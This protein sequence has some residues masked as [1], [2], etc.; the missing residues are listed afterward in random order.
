MAPR[1]VRLTHGPLK[2]GQRSTIVAG[3][4]L[5]GSGTGAAAGTYGDDSHVAQLVVDA[6]GNITAIS[7]VAIAG[8][9][10]GAPAAHH[11]THENGGS[12]EVSLDAS[13]I[14]TGALAYARLPVGTTASTV[15]AGDDSRMTNAR[16]PTAHH[17]T[18]E[19]G[20]ADELALD[21]AQ[22]TSGTIDDARIPSGIARDSEVTTAVSA[23]ATARDAAI[24]LAVANLINSS[25]GALDTLKELADALGDDASFAATMTTALGGKQP[26][27]GALT[28]IV[29]LTP[30]NDDIIQRKSGTWIN[31]TMP[32]LKTDLVLVKGDIGLGNVDNVADASKPVSTAQAA[33]DALRILDPS[34]ANDDFLQRKAGAWANRTVAQVKTDLGLVYSYLFGD[35]SDG[36]VNF[37][38]TTTLLGLVPSSNVY[39]L[40]RDLYLAGGSQLSASAVISTAGFRIFCLGGAL[41]IG[42]SATV[43]HTANPASTSTGGAAGPSTVNGGLCGTK[44]G[45]G[46]AG[47]AGATGNA[48]STS[49][50]AAGGAGGIATGGGMGGGTA[51]GLST[52]AV[53]S[54]GGDPRNVWQAQALATANLTPYTGGAGGAGGTAAAGTGLGGGGGA[55]GGIVM[56]YAQQLINSGT[57]SAIGGVGGQGTAGTSTNVGGGGGGGGGAI[58]LVVG[59]GSSTGTLSVA[60]GA[61]G[62]PRGTGATG[63]TGSTGNTYVLNA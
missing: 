25:P 29:A 5:G 39:T 54:A 55:G 37:D 34:G 21:S 15:A 60:G 2:V 3:I 53:A 31:R 35:G 26:L 43:R 46:A 52:K 18:H 49:V 36:I 14:V 50:G 16:T 11:A 19:H 17:T 28:A 45:N 40:T 61:G 47:A 56:I 59:A 57:I 23:E 42:A 6:D 7:E 12:D 38:G 27:A 48:T 32:Q 4:P 63:A 44:G 51:G 20:G 24:A 10:G 33:A 22:I 58:I 8:G 13:Q 62:A 41:T 1:Y 30:A 9:G